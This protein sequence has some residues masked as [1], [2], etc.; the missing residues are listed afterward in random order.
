MRH[1]GI[2]PFPE[3]VSFVAAVITDFY[4]YP[5]L[6]ADARAFSPST[7]RATSRVARARH[8]KFGPSPAAGR[9]SPAQPHRSEEWFVL[10]LD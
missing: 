8:P 7:T 9:R 4:G 3:T 1:R 6:A 2:P 10:H 5:P